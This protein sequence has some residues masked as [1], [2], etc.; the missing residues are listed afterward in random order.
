[1][2]RNVLYFLVGAL[3]VVVIILGYQAY[4]NQKQPD[5]L[6]INVDKSGVEIKNK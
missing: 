5:G 4:Q 3:A 6:H 2:N 1:M